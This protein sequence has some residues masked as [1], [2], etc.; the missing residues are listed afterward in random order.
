MCPTV[1]HLHY[2]SIQTILLNVTSMDCCLRR[3]VRHGVLWQWTLGTKICHSSGCLSTYKSRL[4]LPL[5]TPHC[6]YFP[7][8]RAEQVPVTALCERAQ[9]A[10]LDSNSARVTMHVR[11]CVQ[12]S[13]HVVTM[14][15]HS[16]PTFYSALR[17][18]TSKQQQQQEQQH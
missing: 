7:K 1:L 10:V 15:W 18:N 17:L 5:P 11:T 16:D 14:H 6:N 3:P 12:F 13:C 2:K 8:H 4:P 9:F